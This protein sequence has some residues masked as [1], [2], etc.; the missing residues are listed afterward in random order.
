MK[1]ILLFLCLIVFFL[2]SYSQKKKANP[3]H[4]IKPLTA[5]ESPVSDDFID[6]IVNSDYAKSLDSLK[7]H[8]TGHKVIN[9]AT[10]NAGFIL[11]LD[12]NS[13]ALAYRIENK[14]SSEFG[15][16]SI[17]KESIN[18]INSTKLGNAADAS[19]DNSPYANERNI[20]RDEVR[21]SHGKLIEGLAIGDNTFNF[22][23]EDGMELDFQISNDK[24]NTPS[25]RVFWEQW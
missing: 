1:I 18:K 15:S 19:I 11:Y 10:G 22:A 6:K 7:I 12:N 21:K 4:K 14:I 25:I 16:D 17:P 3:L 24:N 5:T 2:I 13:W 9:S 20:I 8:V 23:F